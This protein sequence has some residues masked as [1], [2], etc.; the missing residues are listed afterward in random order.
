[1]IDSHHSI[2][3]ALFLCVAFTLPAHVPDCY[4][5]EAEGR[6]RGTL[7]IAVMTDVHYLSP[8][9]ADEG[10]A[11]VAF[12]KA[13]GRKTT[14]LHAVLNNVIDSLKEE[15]PDILLVTGDLTNHGERQSHLDFIT[16]LRPLEKAGIRIF[17]IPGNHDIHIPDA[18]RYKGSESIPVESV[19][20]DE[21]ARLYGSFGY[22]DALRR[23]TT[24]LSYLAM[25]NERT[26][27]L[28]IDSNRYDEHTTTSVSAGR[29]R[30]QTMEWALN[31]LHEAKD[32]GI[33]VL[34]MMHHGLVEHMP[35][36]E[37]FFPITWWRIG[38]SR[39]ISWPTP[40]LT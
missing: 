14:E 8:L 36:Q 39:L 13:T 30:Q 32:K 34:G 10:E 29:I 11:L 20:A 16:L 37:A 28:C 5:A 18:R 15:D 6:S 33:T 12:E 24:S 22:E 23:D 27:L 4:D 17:V 31:I 9:L 7:K 19:S 21:F 35:Y 3:A 25:I 38:S 26:W 2:L 1:M 40:D